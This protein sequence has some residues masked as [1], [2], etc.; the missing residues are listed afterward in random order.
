MVGHNV[1][2][3]WNLE[4]LLHHAVDVMAIHLQRVSFA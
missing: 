1:V 4:G 3:Q 2:G